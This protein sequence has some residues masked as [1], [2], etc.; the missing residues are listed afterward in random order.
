MIFALVARTCLVAL[1]LTLVACSAEPNQD[2]GAAVDYIVI[3]YQYW[4][5]DRVNEVH[6]I[7][8]RG[9][10]EYGDQ[11]VQEGGTRPVIP[12]P[13][14]APAVRRLISAV[15]A[16]PVTRESAVQ[17]LAKK[18]TAERI[19]ARWRPSRSSP[20]EPCGD[21]QKRALVSAK[22]QSDG[23]ERLVRSRLEGPWTFR[24]TD[25]Y[26]TLTI[27]IRLSDGRRWL[28]HSASQLERMLPWSYLR[29]DEKNIDEIAAAPV[30][31]SVELADAIAGLLPVGERTRDRFSDAWLINQLAQEVHL[32]HM[33]ACFP[34]QKK[35]PPSG[36]GVSAVQ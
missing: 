33:D 23:V 18:T 30:T 10:G 34:S 31:W 4:G 32:Q 28:L 36:S 22:L 16:R 8:P 29:G 20:P 24:W 15:Q 35:P 21:E 12:R 7:R 19:M 5:W 3:H 14:G 26:P 1:L 11:W 6:T 17:T 9:D 13:V 25:D 27:D 2:R